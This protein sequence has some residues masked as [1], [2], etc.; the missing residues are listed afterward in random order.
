MAA[1][2]FSGQ[3]YAV[4]AAD[5]VGAVLAAISIA[6]SL[7]IAAGLLRRGVVVGGRWSAGQP[8]RRVIVTII[9]AGVASLLAFFWLAQGQ[10]SGW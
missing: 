9:G 6:G 3:H 4:A 8:R 5:A 2:N 10:F 1:T 7:W